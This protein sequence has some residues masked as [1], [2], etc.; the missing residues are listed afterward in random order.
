MSGNRQAASS[1]R[2]TALLALVAALLVVSI[3]AYPDQA[4]AASLHGL[5]VWWKYVFPALLPFLILSEMLLGFGFVHA[6]GALLEPLMR[7]MLRIPG[8][9]GWALA[10]GGTI[11][12]PAAARATALLHKQGLLSRGEA[13]RLLAVSHLCSPVFIVTVVGT[14][15]LHSGRLGLA[16][17]AIHAA[18]AFAVG[19]TLRLWPMRSASAETPALVPVAQT[20]SAALTPPAAHVPAPGGALLRRAYDALREAHA[21]DGRPFGKLLGDSVSASVQT[22]MMIGGYMI[23]FSVTVQI[24]DITQAIRLLQEAAAYALQTDSIRDAVRSAVSGLLEVHIGSYAASQQSGFAGA[25]LAA[26]VAALLGWG[27]LSSHAQVQSLTYEAKLRY[28]PF[29]AARLLHAAYSYVFTFAAWGPLS[30][31]LG[32]EPS[33]ADEGYAAQ[34][35]A[36]AL[37]AYPQPLPPLILLA[38]LLAAMLAGSFLVS[39][40]RARRSSV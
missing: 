19:L 27:G 16:L 39:A 11:G 17:A 25:P 36:A 13:E 40:M 34:R 7:G 29:L 12:Q 14:G 9:G 3:I 35:S 5:T 21:K 18:A 15:F 8:V 32:A 20:D 23:I 22:L 1:R 31:W 33:F 38:L 10:M 2:V 30:V 6:L 28:G 37:A 26:F 24:I 4:F